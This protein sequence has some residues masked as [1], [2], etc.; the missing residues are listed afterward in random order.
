MVESLLKEFPN[1]LT[2]RVRMP[3]VESL[4]YERNFIT[5]I[6]KYDKVCPRVVGSP[7]VDFPPDMLVVATAY[8]AAH[9]CLWALYRSLQHLTASFLDAATAGEIQCQVTAV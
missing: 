8:V 1:V 4:T 9:D 7:A 5:K 3:I 6:I 2:L